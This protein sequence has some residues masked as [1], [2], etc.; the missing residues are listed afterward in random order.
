[1]GRVEYFDVL[2]RIIEKSCTQAHPVLVRFK[3]LIVPA[4][5]TS[6]PEFRV[7]RKRSEGHRSESELIVHL[8][9]RCTG[10]DAEYLCVREFLSGK[11]EYTCLYSHCQ[12][13]ASEGV[14][15]DEAG[16]CDIFLA[17]PCLDI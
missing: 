12:S 5:L 8:H 11:L 6:F 3:D 9:D 7:I 2:G 17:A 16:V 15:Y 4:A 10:G 14:C 1:M 13:E